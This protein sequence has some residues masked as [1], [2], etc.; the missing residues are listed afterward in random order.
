M[1]AYAI[2]NLKNVELGPEIA[3]YLER[4]D[5]TFAPFGG[6]WVIHGAVPEV[7]EGEWA[8][9]TIVIEFPDRERA[10]AWYASPAYQAILPLRTDHSDGAAI[11]VDGA[12]RGHRG[13]DAL[14]G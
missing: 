2:A 9:A 5:D 14:S 12:E 13:I 11:I 8:D 4:I 10:H 3:A 1:P 7:I 6:R